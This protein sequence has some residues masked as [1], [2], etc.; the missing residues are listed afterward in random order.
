MDNTETRITKTIEILQSLLLQDYKSGEFLKKF[1]VEYDDCGRIKKLLF[2][3]DKEDFKKNTDKLF[4]YNKDKPNNC[5]KERL[6]EKVP[7]VNA[8]VHDISDRLK[9][10]YGETLP[11]ELEQELDYIISQTY[12]ATERHLNAERTQYEARQL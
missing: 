8:L 4:G 3:R 2:E 1:E 5:F 7:F 12:Q 10:V 9:E 11:H 6:A